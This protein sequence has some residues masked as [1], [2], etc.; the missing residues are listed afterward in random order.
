MNLEQI[1]SI[2]ESEQSEYD[3]TERIC[4]LANA[5]TE[6]RKLETEIIDQLRVLIDNHAAGALPED[7]PSETV[8]SLP[9]DKVAEAVESL[10]EDTVVEA[11]GSLSEDSPIVMLG[12]STRTYNLLTKKSLETLGDILNKSKWEW[13]CIPGF[14]KAM[15]KEIE[16]KMHVAGFTNFKIWLEYE[17]YKL[18]PGSLSEDSPIEMLG[19]SARTYNI[20]VGGW[21]AARCSPYKTIRDI[22]DV[23]EYGWDKVFG[24]GYGTTTMRCRKKIAKEIEDKMH[25][26]GFTNFKIRLVEPYR[27]PIAQARTSINDQMARALSDNGSTEMV[28]NL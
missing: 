2:V 15:A 1:R 16:N 11:V 23:P 27:G 12:L 28:E 10:P 4:E 24:Y 17:G 21:H 7:Q 3:I 8:E 14:G 19:L 26:A 25:V 22:L 5:L 13:W 6:L 20:L 9:E 18:T